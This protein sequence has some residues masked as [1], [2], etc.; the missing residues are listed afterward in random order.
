M[1]YDLISSDLFSYEN[2]LISGFAIAISALVAAVLASLSPSISQMK[3]PN[4]K[5]I[6]IRVK[7]D[8]IRY[9]RRHP[10]HHPRDFS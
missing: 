1:T 7:R 10:G 8:D 5:P 9:R 2:L 3:Q 6:P 4:L